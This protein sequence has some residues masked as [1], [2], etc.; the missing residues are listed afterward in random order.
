MG[1]TAVWYLFTLFLLPDTIN[2]AL[3]LLTSGQHE[4]A[5]DIVK[6]FEGVRSEISAEGEPQN[7]GN[8]FIDHAVQMQMVRTQYNL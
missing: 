2:L 4:A 3:S 1:S 5:F 8:F 6:K 7:Q